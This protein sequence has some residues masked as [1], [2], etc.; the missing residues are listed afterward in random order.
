MP[1]I[2]RSSFLNQT[3]VDKKSEEKYID[4]YSADNQDL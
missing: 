3:K 2:Y 4:S 1:Q